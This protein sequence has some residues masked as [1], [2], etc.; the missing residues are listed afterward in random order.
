MNVLLEFF[1]SIAVY[2]LSMQQRDIYL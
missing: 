1:V 2:R